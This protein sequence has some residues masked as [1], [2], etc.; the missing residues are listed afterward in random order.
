[1]NT[2]L[3]S[4]LGALMLLTFVVPAAA[5][6]DNCDGHSIGNPAGGDDCYGVCSD[7]DPDDTCKGVCLDDTCNPACDLIPIP[8]CNQQRAPAAA[9][10]DD[11]ECNGY[12]VGSWCVGQDNC[13]RIVPYTVLPLYNPLN[14]QQIVIDLKPELCT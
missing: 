3:V 2:N 12:E 4:L 9:S 6:D 8:A 10:A 13:Q 14:G 7:Q 11:E 1:M 5:A